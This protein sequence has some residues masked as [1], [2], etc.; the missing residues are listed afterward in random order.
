MPTER[1]IL[2]FSH[3][4]DQGLEIP[5]VETDDLAPVLAHIDHEMELN[6]SPHADAAWRPP[7][8][9]EERRHNEIVGVFLTPC[10]PDDFPIHPDRRVLPA[11]TPQSEATVSRGAA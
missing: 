11:I 4:P 5:A 2:A 8:V 10:A 9:L 3:R 6:G 1:H 7:P